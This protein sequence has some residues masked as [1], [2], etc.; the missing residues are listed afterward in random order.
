MIKCQIKGRNT[1]I[2]INMIDTS[3][4]QRE[5]NMTEEKISMLQI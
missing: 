3:N 5:I 1:K 2:F 4:I